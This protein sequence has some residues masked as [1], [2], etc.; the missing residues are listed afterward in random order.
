MQPQT[1]RTQSGKRLF[2]H[3]NKHRR[4]NVAGVLLAYA[5][6][7]VFADQYLIEDLKKSAMRGLR[8]YLLETDIFPLTRGGV[9][10]LIR[11]VYDS[12]HTH[13][14][15]EGQPLDPL[16]KTVVQFIV[17]HLDVFSDFLEHRQLLREGGD[18]AMDLHDTIRRWL[19]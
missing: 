6:L 5:R 10:D 7:Y 9:I 13:S 12:D 3:R 1:G 15:S 4:D 11:Y 2:E 18:Y 8:T 17:L 19:L 16:R 14:S